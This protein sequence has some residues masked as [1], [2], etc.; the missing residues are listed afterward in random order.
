VSSANITPSVRL[1]DHL[2]AIPASFFGMVFGI[3]GLGNCWQVASKIWAL[4]SGIGEGFM[5]IGSFVWAVLL[6][7]Y[8]AKWFIHSREARV[9]FEHPIQC[10]FVGL[11]PVSTMLV[12][13]AA[14]P[15]SRPLALALF[16]AGMSGTVIFALYRTGRLWM[17]G[18]DPDATTPVLY[19]PSVAG[20]FVTTIVS[21]ALGF[22]G[23]AL[24]AFGA[25]LFAWVSIEPVLIHRLYTVAALPPA[26]R[27]TLGIQLAPPSV[28]AVA[29]LSVTSGR[30]DLAAYSFV[31]YGLLQGLILIRLL[32]WILEQPFATSYWAFTFGVAALPLA[33]LRIVERG[34]N[35]P[36]SVLAPALF[37]TAN[38]IILGIGLGTILLLIKGRLL[39]EKATASRL[40]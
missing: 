24:L 34:D 29:Y 2:P 17:G 32:P 12:A 16:V 1:K 26:L 27:P 20:C 10:C 7:L 9:E 3:L 30:P 39:P 21:G 25:G 40:Q 6:I 4:P 23:W 31:G 15:Y 18:R 22:E 19:L 5:L 38:A 28:G 33:C 14:L 36:I 37:V 35:G 8:L 11:V 13:L